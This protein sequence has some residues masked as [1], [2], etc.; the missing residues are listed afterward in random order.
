MGNV[1]T[2]IEEIKKANSKGGSRKDE[3]RVM[4]A[5]LNDTDFQV[6]V[7][8]NEGKESEYCPA[9]VAKNMVGDIISS[10]TNVSKNEAQAI[11]N[12]YTFTNKD[13][14]KMVTISKEFVN[15]YTDS[16]RKF[17]LGKRETSNVSLYKKDVETRERNFPKAVV[18]KDGKPVLDD[19]GN[20]KYETSHVTVPAHTTMRTVSRCPEHLK[21]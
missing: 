13:A 12:D 17:N 20:A 6:G 14:E 11:A 18:G 5:M 4:K 8:N 21:K 16:G 7:Y 2:L 15:V 9:E 3:V 19:K 1:K 10:A